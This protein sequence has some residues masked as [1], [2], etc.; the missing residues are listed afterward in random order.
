MNDMIEIKDLTIEFEERE[1][2]HIVVD[3]MNLSIKKGEVVGLVGES[4]SGKSMT[5][6]ALAG[7]LNRQG[8]ITS[9]QILFEE[10]DLL[11]CNAKELHQ[12]QGNKISMI[13]Q[14]PMTSLNPAMKIGKQV[15]EG[16]KL[17]KK[18]SKVERKK[19]VIEILKQVEMKDPE[20]VY[21]Q[22]PH[23]LSGGMRQR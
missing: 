15:E 3:H 2:S 11:T 19:Q 7:L 23:Q 12:Y 9:G 14:E 13:F 5:A 6:L 17:H 1:S 21:K 8:K 22:Y 10:R 4:G 20:K 16:L 18:L